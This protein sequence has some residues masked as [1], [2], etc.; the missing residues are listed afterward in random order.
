MNALTIRHLLIDMKPPL[1]RHWI[2]GEV[3]LSAFF[4]ALSMSFPVGEQFFIDALREGL[5]QLP[6]DE[7]AAWSREIQGFVGQEATHRR[8]HELYNQ[9]L[10]ALGYENRWAPRVVKRLKPLD[11]FHDKRHKVAI[12]AATEHLTAIFAAWLLQHPPVLATAPERM[13]Q[14]WLWHA[15]EELEH[16]CTAFDL[17]RALDGNEKWRKR[18]MRLVSMHFALDVLRQTLHHLWHDDQL[19]KAATWR[20]ARHWLFGRQGLLRWGASHWRAYF[21]ADFHP[22][23]FDDGLAHQWLGQHQDQWRTVSKP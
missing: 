20:G 22:S 12:T 13:R 6:P 16:R 5:T 19:F 8:L 23:Q 9:H 1:A 15:S 7:K 11:G 18:W 2:G 4:D 14:L 10:A 17:Y 21:H 3:F